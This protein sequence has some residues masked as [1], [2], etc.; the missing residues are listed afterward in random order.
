MFSLKLGDRGGYHIFLCAV[1]VL[2]LT[3]IL[4]LVHDACVCFFAHFLLS[5]SLVPLIQCY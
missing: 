2:L 4:L 1:F 3:F 5:L